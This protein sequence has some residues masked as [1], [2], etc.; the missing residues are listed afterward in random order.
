MSIRDHTGN[1]VIFLIPWVQFFTNPTM[2]HPIRL[3]LLQTAYTTFQFQCTCQRCCQATDLRHT[4]WGFYAAYKCH[5]GK[6]RLSLW[7]LNIHAHARPRSLVYRLLSLQTQRFVTFIVWEHH[8]WIRSNKL[9][10][11]RAGLVYGLTIHVHVILVLV[12]VTSWCY[13]WGKW[14][15]MRYS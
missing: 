13:W 12:L 7:R 3:L 1:P 8:N 14:P 5:K 11:C 6:M 9:F 10:T 15:Y 4:K 2:A